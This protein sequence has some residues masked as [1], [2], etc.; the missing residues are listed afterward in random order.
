MEYDVFISHAHEDKDSVARPLTARLSELGVKVWLD[1]FELMLGDSLRRSVERGLSQSKFGIVILSQSFFRK[2]WTQRELDVL[3]SKEETA[4]KVILPI[5]HEINKEEVIKYSP[6]LADKLA[7]STEKG[8]ES[9]AQQILSV[10]KQ[11]TPIESAIANIS[12]HN[13]Q[14]V[15][16]KIQPV[17]NKTSKKLDKSMEEFRAVSSCLGIVLVIALFIFGI[18]ALYS[19][20]SSIFLEETIENPA[21]VVLRGCAFNNNQFSCVVFNGFDDKLITKI[22]VEVKLITPIGEKIIRPQLYSD[23]YFSGGEPLIDSRY[24]INWYYSSKDS[25]LNS[26]NIKV[27]VKKTKPVQ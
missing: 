9:V 14:K 24:K 27:T 25:S 1:E 18:S 12:A 17:S 21:Q 7:A 8:I 26:Q 4:Q 10:V 20:C 6:L 15:E 13:K 2:E 11:G 19:T 5:W 22:E 16:T 23:G 3:L